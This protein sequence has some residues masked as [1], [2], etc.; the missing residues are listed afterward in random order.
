MMDKVSWGE[1]TQDGD[2]VS[3]TATLPPELP[4]PIAIKGLTMAFTFT[5]EDQVARIDVSP[6]M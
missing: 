2:K 6:Q 4:I 5:G 1:P 3:V